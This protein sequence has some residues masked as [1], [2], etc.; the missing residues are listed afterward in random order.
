MRSTHRVALGV[1]RDET[2]EQTAKASTN[3][4]DLDSPSVQ[5]SPICTK[6]LAHKARSP[7]TKS[8][9]CLCLCQLF[10][11]QVALRVAL[12]QA[13]SQPRREPPIMDNFVVY[14]GFTLDDSLQDHQLSE[15]WMAGDWVSL[16]K[17]KNHAKFGATSRYR[18]TAFPDWQ[19]QSNVPGR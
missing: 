1:D 5:N 13:A 7:L 11:P 2:T 12:L 18:A 10:R 8:I 16:K 19:T 3:I 17:K 14:Q 9:F 4:R 15:P 6:F